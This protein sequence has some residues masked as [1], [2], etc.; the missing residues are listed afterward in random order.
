MLIFAVG[1]VVGKEGCNFLVSRLPVYKRLNAIDICLVNGEN[2]AQGNG[3]SPD[4]CE[5]L[6]LAGAGFDNVVDQA[7]VD[8]INHDRV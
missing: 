2:S 4:S 8:I 1:D 3:I 6:F 7:L 5:Q